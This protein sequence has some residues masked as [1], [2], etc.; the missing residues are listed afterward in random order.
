LVISIKTLLDSADLSVEEIIG[1]LKVAEDDNVSEAGRDGDKLYLTEEQWL[2]R[3]KQKDYAESQRQGHQVRQ[4][5]HFKRRKR[6]R[7]QA[8]SG[9]EQ[10]EVPQLW[11]TWPLGP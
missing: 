11:Q 1:R 6:G 9:P 8:A 5:I 10:G 7:V 2:E 3:Y 4:Q